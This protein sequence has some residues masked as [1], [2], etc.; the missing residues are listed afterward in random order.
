MT[1]SR[2][3]SITTLGAV[4]TA[5]PPRRSFVASDARRHGQACVTGEASATAA[6]GAALPT[7]AMLAGVDNARRLGTI[8]ARSDTIYPITRVLP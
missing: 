7:P 4:S 2:T 5:C 3:P 1:A 6:F 8:M